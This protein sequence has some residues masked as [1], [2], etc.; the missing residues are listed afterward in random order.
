[1]KRLLLTVSLAGILVSSFFPA[2]NLY[3]DNLNE[4]FLETL[5]NADDSVTVGQ[6]RKQCQQETKTSS[7]AS[8]SQANSPVISNATM[9]SENGPA[10]VI[11]KTFQAKKPAYFPH[12]IHQA[13]YN[14]GECHHGQTSLGKLVKYTAKTN[15]DKCTSCHN[16]D[17]ANEELNSFK[18]IGHK[19]CRECHKKNQDITAAKCSTCHHKNL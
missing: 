8:S 10:E 5:K 2:Q 16:T 12:K 7:I 19:L 14:C 9:M 6:L 18:L 1:M 4:C 17:M 15:I 3:G 13:K 11:L